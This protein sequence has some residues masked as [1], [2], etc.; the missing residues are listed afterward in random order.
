MTESK[1]SPTILI[2]G[3]TGFAGSHLVEDLLEKGFSQVHVT[4]YGETTGFVS[5]ILPQENIHQLDLTQF[6]KTKTL[7]AQLQPDQIYH[8]AALSVVGTSFKQINKV[9]AVNSDIQLSLLQAVKQETPQAKILS[10]GSALEYQPQTEPLSESSP[11]GPV[12]PYGVSK[13]NQDM[14]AYYFYRQSDL[15]IIRTRSFNHIGERQAPGFVVPDFCR[16]IALIEQGKQNEI[17]VGNLEAVRDFTDVK[18]TVQAYILLMEKG[19]AG[20]VYN[21]GSGKGHSIQEL[22]DILTSLSKTEIKVETD[23]G[24]HRP[25]SV[26]QV[27]ADNSKIKQLGWEPV[28]MLEKTLERTLNYYRQ[29]V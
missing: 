8:L 4:T 15:N 25:V 9:L 19:A 11:L 29:T 20:D 18:D 22:L 26:P 2:T 14:L 21:V 12:S 10:I 16:Q 7:L 5:E 17:K 24:K 1:N 28:I 13:V 3:G 23:P 6:E 27:V